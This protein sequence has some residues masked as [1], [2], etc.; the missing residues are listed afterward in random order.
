MRIPAPAPAAAPTSESPA[1]GAKSQSPSGKAPHRLRKKRKEPTPAARA[2][3][4][5]PTPAALLADVPRIQRESMRAVGKSVSAPRRRSMRNARS[6]VPP[7][8]RDS[9]ALPSR[10]R[11]RIH[12]PALTLARPLSGGTC[13]AVVVAARARTVAIRT[14]RYMR[15]SPARVQPN[16]LELSRERALRRHTTSSFPYRPRQRQPTHGRSAPAGSNSGLGR[17]SRRGLRRPMAAA[18]PSEHD[19][20]EHDK[21]ERESIEPVIARCDE[22]HHEAKD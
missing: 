4:R 10:A 19:L 9:R 22:K 6:G 14:G 15:S 18:L 11:I 2:P 3:I 12:C 20:H 5:A 16:E 17:S 8:T 13:A 1:I 7:T 21:E